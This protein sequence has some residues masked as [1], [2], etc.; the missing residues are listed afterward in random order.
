M[1]TNKYGKYDANHA[2]EELFSYVGLFVIFDPVFDE[3]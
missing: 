1:F 2:N 3:Q